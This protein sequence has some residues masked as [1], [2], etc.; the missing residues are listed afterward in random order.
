MWL[1]PNSVLCGCRTEVSISLLAASW[2]CSLP[3]LVTWFPPSSKPAVETLPSVKPLSCIKSL[4]LGR[5]LSLLMI[6]LIS[7]EYPEAF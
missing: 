6:D 4:S 5:A 3:L 1:W 7:W 2:G